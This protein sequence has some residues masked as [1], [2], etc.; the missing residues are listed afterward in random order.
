VLETPN[1]IEVRE[2][3]LSLVDWSK[4]ESI[5]D[6]GCGS[7]YDL[8]KMAVTTPDSGRLQGIDNS[9]KSVLAARGATADDNRYQ[10]D[11]ADFSLGMPF[12]SGSFDVVFSN[13]VLECITDKG[14]HLR[15]IHRVLRP[16]GTVLCAHYDWD[17]QI[18][19]G[20]DK[21]LT[22]KIIHAFADW[23]QAWMNDCDGWMGRRLW[24]VFES[25]KLFS[26]AIQSRTLT[27]TDFSPKTYGWNM[28]NSFRALVR[29]GTISDVDYSR[30][31]EHIQ[32]QADRGEHIYTI[33]MFAYHGK[34][35]L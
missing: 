4:A 6:I 25:S 29:Q 14:Q 7:G 24:Q 13:N 16:G 12:E 10:F 31:Y 19:D 5:L 35:I 15:E 32:R 21:D 9:E 17:S 3:L 33:T 11:I 8:R 20:G 26:G 30:F 27:E 34:A 22:R 23:K 1:D 28:I 18:F 2:H